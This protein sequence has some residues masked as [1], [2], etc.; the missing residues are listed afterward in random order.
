MLPLNGLN[1]LPPIKLLGNDY[2][3]I[4]N[5]ITLFKYLVVYQDLQAHS[6]LLQALPG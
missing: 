3:Q 1:V 6:F 4:L 2:S 5:M